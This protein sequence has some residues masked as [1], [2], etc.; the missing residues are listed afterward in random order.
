MKSLAVLMLVMLVKSPLAVATDSM[1]KCNLGSQRG[2]EK[3]T[4]SS[5]YEEDLMLP[6]VKAGGSGYGYDYNGEFEYN[7]KLRGFK[8]DFRNFFNPISWIKCAV[9][10][11]FTDQ[12]PDLNSD[13]NSYSESPVA[14]YFKCQLGS[15]RGPEKL[16]GSSLSEANLAGKISSGGAS[17][18]DESYLGS[19][20]YNEIKRGFEVSFKN[21]MNNFSWIKCAVVKKF[22]DQLP[23]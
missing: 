13:S 21:E 15:R 12:L 16:W 2:L 11:N 22:D 7:E 19:F 20:R 23:F 10:K 18:L 8:V 5:I 1:F 6:L 17:G 14:G 4:A 9:V 3:E